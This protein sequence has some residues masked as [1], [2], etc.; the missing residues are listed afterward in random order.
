M[1]EFQEA[2]GPAGVGQHTWPCRDAAHRRLGDTNKTLEEQLNDLGL[3][4]TV[5]VPVITLLINGIEMV[6]KNLKAA[7]FDRE[8]TA[9]G[10]QRL[11]GY[12]K[13]WSQKDQCFIDAPNKR[14]GCSGRRRPAPV[15]PGPGG[16]AARGH[17]ASQTEEEPVDPPDWRL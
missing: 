1:Q 17:R 3:V 4:N 10:I 13:Q 14:N 12:V 7:F 8:R 15:G 16:G 9:K 5:I 2:H 11:D 6:R